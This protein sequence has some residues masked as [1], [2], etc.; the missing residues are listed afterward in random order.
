MILAAGKGT[1]MKSDL[2]KVVHPIGGRPMVCAVVDSCRAVGCEPV[3]AVVGYQQE[4]VR[5]ALAGTG[6]AFAVQEP[7]LG[8][9]HAVQCAEE[10]LRARSAGEGTS[11]KH[12]R[13][14]EPAAHARGSGPPIA[15]GGGRHDVFVL[16]GDGPLIRPETLRALLERHRTSGAAATLAT[17]IID[18]PT[19][20]GRIVRDA[21]G[22]FREIVEHK[23]A[24]PAQ[25]AIREVNPSYYCFRREDLFAALRD[26]RR[27]EASG[28]YYLTD[29]LSLLLARGKHVEVVAAVPP[30]DVLSINT[31][32]DL[33]MVDSIY[34]S[35]KGSPI[36]ETGRSRSDRPTQA[37]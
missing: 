20:Y 34:R 12:E 28:E 27:N 1:R 21:A 22:Q 32:E 18:D 13:G 3:V 26:V 6:V 36:T 19:G 2:P 29:V 25:R 31:P 30:E 24:T 16:C 23:D 14:D 9:G 37:A 11:P 10:A 35:R 7:Q 17:A 4:K 8:T 33:A 5:A 15:H